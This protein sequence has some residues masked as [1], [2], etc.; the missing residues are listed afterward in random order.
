MQ[1]Q[2]EDSLL[3]QV[4]CSEGRRDATALLRG[5][6]YQ[7]LIAIEKLIDPNTLSVFC[8]FIED[9]FTLDSKN[10]CIITQ[11]KYYAS[12]FPNN[13]FKE[14]TIDLYVNYLKLKY[15]GDY[16]ENH[17]LSNIIPELNVYPGPNKKISKPSI[18]VIEKWV[19]EY[20][21]NYGG[22]EEGDSKYHRGAK[23]IEAYGTDDSLLD[24]TN[25]LEVYSSEKD[26]SEFR[27]DVGNQLML[28]IQGKD[29]DIRGQEIRTILLGTAYL[30]VI[31]KYELDKS[32]TGLSQDDEIIKQKEINKDE[33]VQHLQRMLLNEDDSLDSIVKSIVMDEYLRV[34]TGNPDIPEEEKE[35]LFR[36]ALKTKDWLSEMC[37]STEGQE[38]LMN[39]ISYESK[40]TIDDWATKDNRSRREYLWK[41]YEGLVDFLYYL[42]KI[43][44]DIIV[45]K[46]EDESINDLD[47][48]PRSY[49]SSANNEYICMNFPEDFVDRCII[50]PAAARN[51]EK[52]KR[53]III[54]RMMNF[55]PKRWLMCGNKRG[56]FYYD[57]SINDIK[58]KNLNISCINDDLNFYIEC[59]ECIKVDM[60]EW[61][62]VEKCEEC[63]FAKG[64]KK[65]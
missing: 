62:I 65:E 15:Y 33:F 10:G 56:E 20:L 7:E 8:E 52:F 4:A 26:L 12:G 27:E 3:I 43:L 48:D 16:D 45:K 42:W 61:H 19:S 31:E 54:K 5:Y 21:T 40:R 64:C 23:I 35:I 6:K 28:L 29:D 11:A 44:M 38:R 1:N 47:Y 57:F 13:K 49:V 58:E 25:C 46:T 53:D 32:N 9:V 24:F 18:D 41:A 63:I 51:R 60:G 39:T 34:L 30:Y 2:V 37:Q 59:M 22:S 50:L 14:A 17:R 55:R 36:V